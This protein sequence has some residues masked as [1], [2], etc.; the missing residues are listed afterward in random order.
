[1]L[2]IKKEE[3]G[4]RRTGSDLGTVLNVANFKKIEQGELVGFDFECCQ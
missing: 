3:A 2:L 4:T 1:M